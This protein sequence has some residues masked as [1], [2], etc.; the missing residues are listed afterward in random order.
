MKVAIEYDART[1]VDG[2]IIYVGIRRPDCFKNMFW[3]GAATEDGVLS[4]IY[5]DGIICS[6]TSTELEGFSIP[7]LE[8]VGTIELEIPNLMVVPGDYMLDVIFYDQNFEFRSYFLG[9]KRVGF[10]VSSRE[11]KLDEKYGVFYQKPVWRISSGN[12]A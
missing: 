12:R 5:P 4:D 1:R 8:G 7:H 3:R 11:R 10:Q 6:A 9:R 2:P